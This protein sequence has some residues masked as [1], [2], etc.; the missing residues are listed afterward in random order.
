MSGL[1]SV[2]VESSNEIEVNK[3]LADREN[4][5]QLKLPVVELLEAG[6][7]LQKKKRMNSS[8]A[9][10]LTLKPH[11]KKRERIR[12]ASDQPPSTQLIELD[13]LL[14]NSI[15][16]LSKQP[17]TQWGRLS[18]GNVHA[19]LPSKQ[20]SK[21]IVFVKERGGPPLGFSLSGGKDSKLGDKGIFIRSIQENGIAGKDGRLEVGDE[22]TVINE[23]SMEGFTHKMAAE[24]IKVP[25]HLYQCQV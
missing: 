1:S 5:D 15:A 25:H 17:I 10:D 11:E 3:L 22:I 7:S 12:R 20:T 24:K 8:S 19:S 9:Y 16:T 18:T 2:S 6:P 23:E 14:P 13:E 4:L 21:T